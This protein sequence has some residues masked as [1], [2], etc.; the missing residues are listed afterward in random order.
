MQLA[1]LQ[2]TLLS[3]EFVGFVQT[4][5]EVV[6]TVRRGLVMLMAAMTAL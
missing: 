5:A 6:G 4:T 3:V 1:A 2:G